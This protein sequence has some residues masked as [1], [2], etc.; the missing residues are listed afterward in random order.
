MIFCDVM[1]LWCHSKVVIVCVF[2]DFYGKT[3]KRSSI[4]R[5]NRNY[6]LENIQPN[7]E[8]IASLLSLNCIT[9]EQSHF[10]QRLHSTQDKNAELLYVIKPFDETKFSNFAK[11]LRQ[12]NQKTVARI[13][14]NG[15]GITK[16][17]IYG[18]I[19]NI[20]ISLITMMMQ[21]SIYIRIT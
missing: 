10:I 17:F 7:D 2:L 5:N 18:L 1:K 6:L 16:N 15:G 11:C 8:L 21:I 3:K 12:T 13:I 19:I 9:E 4:I 20:L 14:E